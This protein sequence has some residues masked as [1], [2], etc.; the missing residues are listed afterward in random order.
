[1]SFTGLALRYILENLHIGLA[2]IIYIRCMYG[3]FGR[4]MTKYTVIYGVYIHDSGQPYLHTIGK[5]T[6]S[7]PQHLARRASPP[8]ITNK[9]P[10]LV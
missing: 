5:Q 2:R 10:R 9:V 7:V 8:H 3:V 6:L 4:E 1:M